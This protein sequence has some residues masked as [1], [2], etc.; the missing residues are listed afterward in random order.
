VGGARE[1]KEIRMSQQN[2]DTIRGAYEAFGRGD[3][4]G[5]LSSLHE[6]VTWDSPE[7]LPWGGMCHGHQE[8]LAFFGRL[9]EQMAELRVEPDRFVDAGDTVL[10]TGMHRG[11]HREGGEFEARWAM[12]WE[13]RDGKASEFREYVDTAPIAAAM[14]RQ[15][16]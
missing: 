3:I 1:A 10:V 12:V 7:S 15:T 5:V 13:L 16:A 4:P 11:R 6:D 9:D 2:V 8:V 14:E